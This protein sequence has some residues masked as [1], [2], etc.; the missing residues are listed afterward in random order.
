MIGLAIVGLVAATGV[1]IVVAIIGNMREGEAYREQLAQRLGRLRL[2]RALVLFGVDPT[3]YLHTQRMV[4]IEDQMR[5]CVACA[6]ITRCDDALE[7]QRSEDLSFCPNYDALTEL[8]KPAQEPRP[9][10]GA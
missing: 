4:D 8:G 7:R 9:V 6:E 10:A 1:A 3:R 2:G 5:G